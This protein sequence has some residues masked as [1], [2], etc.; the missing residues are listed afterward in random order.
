MRIVHEIPI[1]VVMRTHF[2]RIASSFS[3]VFFAV[4]LYQLSLAK[5]DWTL[6]AV[7]T[8]FSFV[9]MGF[10]L[11][12]EFLSDLE[13]QY[14]K[15]LKIL[16]ENL[17]R[18]SNSP[19]QN[20]ITNPFGNPITITITKTGSISQLDGSIDQLDLMTLEELNEELKAALKVEDYERA[21]K[22]KKRIQDRK[23]T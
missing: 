2:S 19:R 10:T 12:I 22:I 18:L 14:D 21:E 1:F 4:A 5:T 11:V 16:S 7:C 9:F 23:A 13:R 3:F 6:L 15:L 8:G 17:V 20:P